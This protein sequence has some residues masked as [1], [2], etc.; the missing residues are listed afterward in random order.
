MMLAS[1]VV[2]YTVLYSL[3]Q[4]NTMEIK[5]WL[6]FQYMLVQLQLVIGT[7]IDMTTWLFLSEVSSYTCTEARS[8]T[9][10]N[11]WRKWKIIMTFFWSEIV[12]KL[13]PTHSNKCWRNCGTQIRNHSHILSSPKLRIFWE[14]V[15]EALKEVFKR[16]IIKDPKIALLGL[17]LEGTDGRAKNTF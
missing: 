11:I 1:A 10:R 7:M 9:N 13:G 6:T 2:Q 8:V 3:C 14:E 16:N 5:L 15:F 4:G 12:P 17:P